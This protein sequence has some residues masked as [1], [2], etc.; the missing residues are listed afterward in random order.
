MFLQTVNEFIGSATSELMV[1]ARA[2]SWDDGLGDS[3]G[4]ID[5][6]VN[7]GDTRRSGTAHAN[8]EPPVTKVDDSPHHHV[9]FFSVEVSVRRRDV[10]FKAAII[11]RIVIGCAADKTFVQFFNR[12]VVVL[13]PTEVLCKRSDG[14]DE[15]ALWGD[16][17]TCMIRR[18]IDGPLELDTSDA[19]QDRERIECVVS[20]IA[21]KVVPFLNAIDGRCAFVPCGED[22]AELEKVPYQR[23]WIARGK[24]EADVT[25]EQML[26][27]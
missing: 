22:Y 1:E 12:H 15:E 25:R 23:E 21:Y 11:R 26:C 8:K 6:S 9:D 5:F 16:K 3:D 4:A 7:Q 10:V 2:L 14:V 18:Q 24:I 27:L 13:D 19:G 17:A 20:V